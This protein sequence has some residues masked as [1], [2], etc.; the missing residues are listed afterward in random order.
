MHGLK[1]STKKEK[2]LDGSK[3]KKM[4]PFKEGKK[5]RKEKKMHPFSY[6]HINTHP[7]LSLLGTSCGV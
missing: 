6:K 4:I 7:G 3:K 1:V 2:I 5:M